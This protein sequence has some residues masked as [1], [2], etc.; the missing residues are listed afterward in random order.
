MVP[1]VLAIFTIVG[2]TLLATASGVGPWLFA[3]G[4]LVVIGAQWYQVL[5]LPYRIEASEDDIVFVSVKIR[6]LS[7]FDGFH[8]F[9]ARL[10]AANPRIE[11][12][13]C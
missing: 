13:G 4:W 11:L 1:V 6:L 12:R 8:E 10:K 5:S 7:Q 3:I 9:V 2:A